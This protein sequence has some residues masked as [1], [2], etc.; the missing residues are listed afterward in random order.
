MS[1]TAPVKPIKPCELAIQALHYLLHSH[2]RW[3]SNQ[4]YKDQPYS[5]RDLD[6]KKS[7]MKSTKL[8]AR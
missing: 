8:N 7:T 5:A 2:K 1:I 6:I 3:K 4:F